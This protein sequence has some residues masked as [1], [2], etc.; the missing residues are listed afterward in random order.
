M[1]P[2]LGKFVTVGFG[3]IAFGVAFAFGS[4]V[5]MGTGIPLL[6][7]LVNGILVSM[8]LTIGLLAVNRFWTGTIMWLTLSIFA[9]PTTTL[10]PPGL[11]KV[12]IAVTAGFIWDS[13]YFGLKRR[14][15]GLLIGA[16]IASASIMFLLIAALKLGLSAE[17]EAALKKYLGAL[18]II[19]GINFIVTTIGVLLGRQIYMARLSKLSVFKNLQPETLE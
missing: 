14:T 13:I 4:A 19:L 6:G 11:Y 3:A 2:L 1:K 9:I 15:I 16:L 8:V 17:A 18:Y 5:T 7:G 12:V 10:G